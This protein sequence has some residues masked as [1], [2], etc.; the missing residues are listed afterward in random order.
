MSTYSN[1]KFKKV[2]ETLQM[3]YPVTEFATFQHYMNCMAARDVIEKPKAPKT[4]NYGLHF[5]K[6]VIAILVCI[7]QRVKPFGLNLNLDNRIKWSVFIPVESENC[8][9][10]KGN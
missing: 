4:G 5:S 3:T 7:L 2:L 10:L 9:R 1:E 6:L 8:R